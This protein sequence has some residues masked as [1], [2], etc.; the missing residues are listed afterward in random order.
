VQ[1]FHPGIH[2]RAK[3]LGERDSPQIIHCSRCQVAVHLVSGQA[4]PHGYP[5]SNCYGITF[6]NA[7]RKD[8]FYYLL[9]GPTRYIL[10][11]RKDYAINN[12]FKIAKPGLKV[13]KKLH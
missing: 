6:T 13:S 3:A 4:W 11:E 1:N 9:C 8:T 2:G 12:D 5:F 7:C 10:L